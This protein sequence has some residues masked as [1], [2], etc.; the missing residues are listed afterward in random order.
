[1]ERAADAR[2]TGALAPPA[3]ATPLAPAP[4]GPGG[5]PATPL[6]TTPYDRMFVRALWRIAASA[7]SSG[8]R[9]ALLTDGPATFAAMLELIDGACASVLL[10]GYIFRPDAVGHRFADA[11]IAAATRGVRVRALVDWWGRMGTPRSFFRRMRDGGV[12]VRLFNPP[13][14]RSWLGLVP[15]DHRKVLVVDGASGVTGG[16]GIGTEWR[17]GTFAPRRQPWRDTAVR[18]DGPAAAQM[19]E[20]FERMWTRAR[21]RIPRR[22]R[23]LP[24]RP[25][26]SE[27]V[28]PPGVAPGAPSLVGIIEGEPGRLRVAR[29]LQIQSVLA[30][31][32][33]WIAMAYFV[34][35]FAEVEA[36]TGAARDGI[37]VRVLVPGRYDHFWLSL[38]TRRYYRRLLANGVRIWEWRGEM[39]HAKTQV[40]DGRWTS[41]GSTDFNPLGIAINYELDA[42]IDDRDFGARMEATY[43][44]DLSHSEEITMQHPIMRGRNSKSNGS[45]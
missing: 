14:F 22:H 37:D 15:R 19:T 30:E 32:A 8:N 33:I 31:R 7:V 3:P 44:D 6:V 10:E 23:L 29:T 16:I 42:V 20:A 9:V 11:L 45:P 39:M 25:L 17:T 36:L 38:M 13:G 4:S 21:F 12:D 35:S 24:R 28:A 43:L 2:L 26:G 40:I 5:I 1:M 18:I 41:V 34:P 27:P